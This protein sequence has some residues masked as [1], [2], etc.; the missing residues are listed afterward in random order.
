MLIRF[1]SALALALATALAPAAQ[2]CTVTWSS[3]TS[4]S[5]HDDARWT[6]AR[7]PNASD[8]ACITAP[9]TY[10]VSLTSASATAQNLVIGGVSYA[11]FAVLAWQFTGS[12]AQYFADHPMDSAFYVVARLSGGGHK[13]V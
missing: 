13:I 9:G 1:A 3:A 10:T 4:G 2:T 12:A 11:V 7:V 8:T 6:P 5:W